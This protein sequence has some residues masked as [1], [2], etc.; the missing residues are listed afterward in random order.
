M[1]DGKLRVSGSSGLEHPN[2]LY[3]LRR[4]ARPATAR[5]GWLLLLPALAGF[6]YHLVW[7]ARFAKHY[8][9]DHGAVCDLLTGGASDFDGREPEFLLLWIGISLLIVVGLS[10]CGW[11]TIASE[12]S[13]SVKR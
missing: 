12:R 2:A 10:L 5:R 11:R 7:T 6:A 3:R 4:I 8:L 13:I 1:H 9:L